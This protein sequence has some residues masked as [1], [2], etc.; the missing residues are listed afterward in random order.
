MGG[1]AAKVRIGRVLSKLLRCRRGTAEVVGSIMF[2]LIMMFFFT[3][4]FLWHDT[5]T[6][7]MDGVTSEKLN[8]SISVE[9]IAMNVTAPPDCR[10]KVTNNGG[11]G[12]E[13]SRYWINVDLGDNL[14]GENHESYSTDLW[15]AAGEAKELFI[16]PSDIAAGAGGKDITTLIV[17]FKV[18]T[19]SGNMAACSV[20]PYK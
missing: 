12:V 5:A 16:S 3:N 15:L 17:T 1:I 13:L 11:V 6:R 18:V 20:K 14:G 2:L 9:V 7:E 19:T 10:L 4:V 8:S